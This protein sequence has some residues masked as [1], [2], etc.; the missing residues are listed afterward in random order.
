MFFKTKVMIIWCIGEGSNCKLLLK[1]MVISNSG[2][3]EIDL[4]NIN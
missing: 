4:T 2:G 1:T 3:D